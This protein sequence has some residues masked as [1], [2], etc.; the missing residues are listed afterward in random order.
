MTLDPLNL[1]PRDKAA[2]RAWA[3]RRRADQDIKARLS[4]ALRERLRVLPE[5]EAARDILLYLAMPGEVSVESLAE[6]DAARQPGRRYYGPRCAPRRRLAVH[7]YV[8][9]ET[10]LRPGPFGIREPDPAEVPEEDASRLDLVIVPALLLGEGGER[11][12]H[13]GGYYDRFL[14]RLRPDCRRVGVL[15]DALILPHLPQD[16]W[17]QRLDILVT[18]SRVL[19]PARSDR[20]GPNG[21]P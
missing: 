19:R 1:V 10:P 14:P 2:L 16:P 18:E 7:R 8:P 6:R 20:I 5:F 4:D 21:S 9:G 13:G 11:I 15:P 17:D 3:R 12:G